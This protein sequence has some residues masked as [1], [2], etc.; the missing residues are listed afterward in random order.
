ML[1]SLKDELTPL[2]PRSRTALFFGAII[3]AANDVGQ[4]LHPAVLVLGSVSVEVDDFAVVEAD[5][6]TLLDEHV[7]LFFFGEG[8][9]ASLA[10]LRDGLLLRERSPIIDEPLGVGKIDAGTRLTGGFV[11]SC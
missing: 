3:A 9:T 5:S 2:G 8:R 11:V 10:T 1:F 6:E 7:A 4:D